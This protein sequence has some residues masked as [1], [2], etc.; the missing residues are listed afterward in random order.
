MWAEGVSRYVPQAGGGGTT[1]TVRKINRGV[2]GIP[3]LEL[4]SIP[5]VL[6]VVGS[7]VVLEGGPTARG[8]G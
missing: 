8:N 1:F 4:H 6:W 3:S 7:G 5:G 2:V